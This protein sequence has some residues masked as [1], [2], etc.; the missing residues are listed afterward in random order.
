MNPRRAARHGPAPAAAPAPAAPSLA[1]FGASRRLLLEAL[2]RRGT[3]TL[4]EAA[5]DVG[6]SRESVREHVNALAAEGLV[7]RAGVRRA[8][9]GRPE[10]LYRLT[11]RSGALF[12]QRDAA[13]LGEL[14][15]FLA[16]GGQDDVLERFFAR[17]AAARRKVAQRRLAGLTGRRRLEEV[18]RILSED[19]YMAEVVKAP[20]GAT[21][22]LTHCPI[23]ALVAATRLPC[24]AE[25]G[26]VEDLL[27][28]RLK[29]TDYLPEGGASCSYMVR[30][31]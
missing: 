5:A 6:L 8:G 13:L 24:R 31:R 26:L 3:A 20:G 11:S 16:A 28:R 7:A 15:A 29:R 10:L 22:R 23:G 1:A 2:K 21:L 9:P 17:R 30:R 25:L 12:P 14:A 18:A 27:G 19:G 4:L